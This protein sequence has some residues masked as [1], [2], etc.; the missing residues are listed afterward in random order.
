M[1][2][3]AMAVKLPASRPFCASSFDVLCAGYAVD[4]G[5]LLDELFAMPHG[6]A[7]APGVSHASSSLVGWAKGGPPVEVAAACGAE[8]RS[9]SRAHGL[10]DSP[11]SGEVEQRRRCEFQ[12][13]T[14]VVSPRHC[15][16]K[17]DRIKKAL[18]MVEARVEQ[19]PV[20]FTS[21][22]FYLP[23]AVENDKSARE[24]ALAK[25]KD[26]A[27]GSRRAASV[28]NSSA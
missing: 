27:M 16:G 22:D 18:A 28:A 13:S 7:M 8:A 25:L 6:G 5:F 10:V 20:V 15:K 14:R 11:W 24:R 12:H 26:I 1:P 17:R 19:N 3:I 21:G 4:L 23:A 2:P 9:L